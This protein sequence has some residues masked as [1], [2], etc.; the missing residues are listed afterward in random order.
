M[1]DLKDFLIKTE[2]CDFENEKIKK[3]A[4]ELIKGCVSE[5]E[6]AV[7]L[8]YWVRDNILYRVG[9]WNRKAS[10]TLA[11]G[12][13]VCTSKANL[14][15]ALL[16]AVGIPAGYGVMRVKG[17]E[18]F[19]QIVPNRLQNKINQVVSDSHFVCHS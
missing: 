18:Y 4:E 2:Y 10:E 12:K 1:D 15:V 19:G 8:F 16:R 7:A 9:L 5:K 14:L 3:L 11:E 13:G 6:K 17:R